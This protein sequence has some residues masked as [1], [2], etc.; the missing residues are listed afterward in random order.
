MFATQTI[1]SSPT[2]PFRQTGHYTPARPSPLGPRSTNIATPPWTMGSPTRAGHTQ[3]PTGHEE[4]AQTSPISFPKFAVHTE[5]PQR[6][7]D[8]NPNSASN[9]HS[10]SPNFV[11]IA[12][13]PA[14]FTFHSTFH[15][16]SQ[17]Q[18]QQ[19]S[20]IFSPT[21][22]SPASPTPSTRQRYA[23]RYAAQIAN[24]MRSTTS[25]ARSKTRK[26]FLNRVKNERDAG[27]FEARGEQMMMAEYLAD[28]RRWEESMARDVDGVLRGVEGD[29]EDDGMLHDEAELKALDEFVSQEEA[30]ERAWQES[31][32][33]RHGLAEQDAP[34]SD[35]EYDDLFMHLE[36]PVQDMDMS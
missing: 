14:P 10:N 7:H 28:K 36:E 22:P 3:K 18:P 29:I 26:M 9:E 6:Y 31:L 16:T 12:S 13:S 21:S 35:A 2:T 34:F 1:P 30:M 4:N 25:L 8:P 5:Q 24:P 23:E 19:P 17:Q 15:S 32:V 33:N 11:N 27:R 20:N